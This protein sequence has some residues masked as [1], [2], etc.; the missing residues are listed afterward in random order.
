[1]MDTVLKNIEIFL[2]SFVFYVIVTF[3]AGII[4]GSDEYDACV[5]GWFIGSVMFAFAMVIAYG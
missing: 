3:C 1:M 2:A 5:A 4:I